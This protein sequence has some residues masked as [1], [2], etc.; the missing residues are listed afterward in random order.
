MR[1]RKSIISTPYAG[2][3]RIRY[4][5]MI[6]ARSIKAPLRFRCKDNYLLVTMNKFIC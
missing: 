5:G 6:S 2:I 4:M 1:A 3:I